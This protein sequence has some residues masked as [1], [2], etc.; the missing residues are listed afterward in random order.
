[1]A[2]RILLDTSAYSHFRRGH[3]GILLA[4]QQSDEIFLNVVVF[5]ELNAGFQDGH[6]QKKNLASL[7]EFLASPRVRLVDIDIETAGCYVAIVGT[8]R[9]NGTPIPSN[10][11]WIAASAM[12]HGLQVVTTDAHYRAIPQVIVQCFTP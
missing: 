6:L 12:R 1:V 8:L 4:L 10:D 7:D 9:T 11:V 5:A 2:L 3:P